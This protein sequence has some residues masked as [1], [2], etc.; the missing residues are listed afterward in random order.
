MLCTSLLIFVIEGETVKVQIFL[1]PSLL[2]LGGIFFP[3]LVLTPSIMSLSVIT[4]AHVVAI[5]PP[6]FGQCLGL[7]DKEGII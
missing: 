3:F 6:R 7:W 2:F 5:C 1:T 4:H